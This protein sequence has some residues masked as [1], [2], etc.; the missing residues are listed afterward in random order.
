MD[1]NQA[2]RNGRKFKIL[3]SRFSLGRRIKLSNLD[4]AYILAT[5]LDSQQII[6]RLN[7]FLNSF[8]I[9]QQTYLTSIG[10]DCLFGPLF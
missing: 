2:N 9:P 4:V 8:F 6:K 1:K 5:D 7:C 10:I 3:L